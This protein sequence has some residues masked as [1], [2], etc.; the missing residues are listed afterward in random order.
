M[1]FSVVVLQGGDTGCAWA[2]GD[3]GKPVGGA[4]SLKGCS[5]ELGGA[6]EELC[7]DP[8]CPTAAP[9]VAGHGGGDGGAG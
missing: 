6:G 2:S 5:W 3:Q 1:R 9:G 8:F 7:T 4:E